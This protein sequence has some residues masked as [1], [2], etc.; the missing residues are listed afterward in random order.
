MSLKEQ[1]E[2]ARAA[3]VLKARKKSEAEKGGLFQKGNIREHA[4]V[5]HRKFGFSLG[6][7]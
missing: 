1:S 3:K 2:A 5:G 6:C 7:L 4:P